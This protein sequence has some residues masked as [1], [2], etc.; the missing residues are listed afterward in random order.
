MKYLIFSLMFFSVCLAQVQPVIEFVTPIDGGSGTY[1]NPYFFY[2]NVFQWKV[3]QSTSGD[4][5]GI[6][7]TTG[8]HLA[9]NRSCADPFSEDNLAWSNVKN[10]TFEF[11]N[12]AGIYYV[13]AEFESESVTYRDKIFFQF[14]VPPVN[15][16]ALPYKMPAGNAAPVPVV[17]ITNVV[18]G[19]GTYTNPFVISGPVV[20]FRLDGTTDPN[21]VTDINN[22]VMYW[23]IHTTGNHPV[24]NGDQGTRDTARTFMYY[25]AWN[26]VQEWDT[27]ERV[28]KD[29]RYKII[30]C[31]IDQWG[32][33]NDSECVHFVTGPLVP[34]IPE[35]P[36]ES[37]TNAP[38]SIVIL[39]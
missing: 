20:K 23:G 17:R 21:G 27:R 6:L 2:G 14:K 37:T 5:T 24:Y 3:T 34:V 32:E 36:V 26:S 4:M 33:Q 25:P 1:S 7:V 28:S 29:G 10:R 11:K 18:D 31:M 16:F 8:I 38:A 39:K 22:G 12:A 30:Q 15:R 13:Y 19:S 35:K 9:R